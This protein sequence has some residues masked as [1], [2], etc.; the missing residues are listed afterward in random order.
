MLATR[1]QVYRQ[2]VGTLQ[3]TIDVGD[4]SPLLVR[5]GVVRHARD[6]F[7]LAD[8]R[9]VELDIGQ[10]WVRVAERAVITL[11]VFGEPVSCPPLGAYTL[12]GVRLAPDRVGRRLLSVPAMLSA[13]RVAEHRDPRPWSGFPC[14]NPR[15]EA[16][17]EDTAA[18]TSGDF[19][20]GGL[21]RTRM[22]VEMFTPRRSGS[23]RPAGRSRSRSALLLTPGA[24]R[25]H[26]GMLA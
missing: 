16:D 10:T 24:W 17:L 7:V 8:G 9:H 6:V 14:A 22:Q 25:S 2:R 19:H 20:P 11:V 15:R 3:A 5:L 13:T 21:E 1:S 26:A 18:G 23:S 12:E 4:P